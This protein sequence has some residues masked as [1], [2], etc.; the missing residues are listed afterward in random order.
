MFCKLKHYIDVEVQNKLISETL[1]LNVRKLLVFLSVEM[2]Q[3]V[4]FRAWSHFFKSL[5]PFLYCTNWILYFWTWFRMD[6]RH[7]Q[8]ILKDNKILRYF[9]YYISDNKSLT[10][11]CNIFLIISSDIGMYQNTIN[12]QRDT[13]IVFCSQY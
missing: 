1:V 8:I 11:V 2:S 12:M 5:R 7:L 10:S 9:I 6:K 3:K 13:C 4:Q